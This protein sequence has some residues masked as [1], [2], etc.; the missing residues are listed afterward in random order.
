M[1]SAQPRLQLGSKTTLPES[2]HK[3]LL[4]HQAKAHTRSLSFLYHIRA[5]ILHTVPQIM[6]QE[7]FD[8]IKPSLLDFATFPLISDY[9]LDNSLAQD[10]VAIASG[11]F[12]EIGNDL[13]GFTGIDAFAPFTWDHPGIDTIGDVTK[14]S[15]RSVSIHV[16]RLLDS[17]KD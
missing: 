9:N 1:S 11:Q 6:Q 15:L 8:T 10:D 17:S 3:K 5:F 4:A 16:A 13:Q 7:Q 12:A 2:W 14:I